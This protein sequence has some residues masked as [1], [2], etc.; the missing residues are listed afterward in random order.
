MIFAF[1]TR[2]MVIRAASCSNCSNIPLQLEKLKGEPV[3]SEQSIDELC[4][5]AQTRWSG[6]I[7]SSSS[8][9]ILYILLIIQFAGNEQHNIYCS[10][11]YRPTV[12]SGGCI[13]P[14]KSL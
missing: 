3:V 12:F 2:A 10:Y 5:H 14:G 9:G 8:R 11:A 13:S 4:E 6:A 7:K 1:N